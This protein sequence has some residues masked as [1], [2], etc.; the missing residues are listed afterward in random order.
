MTNDERMT[1][2]ECRNTCSHSSLPPNRAEDQVQLLGFLPQER[3][4]LPF[5]LSSAAATMRRKN[6]V[7]RASFL[8]IHILLRKSFLDDPSS[9]SQ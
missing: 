4:L 9:A 8:Q 7:S 3:A 5:K 6:F 1:N 2:I